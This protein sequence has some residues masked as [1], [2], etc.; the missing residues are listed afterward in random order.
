MDGTPEH[1]D[2]GDMHRRLLTTADMIAVHDLRVC[3][4]TSGMDPM[5][6]YLVVDDL[7]QGPSPLRQARAPLK[8][9]FGIGHVTIQVE[10]EALR[11]E[12]V[13]LHV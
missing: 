8:R 13:M 6:C 2:V 1:I 3:T 11:S 10:D 12:A 4:I 7:S 9:D 5:S